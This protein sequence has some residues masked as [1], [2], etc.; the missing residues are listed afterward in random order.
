MVLHELATNAAKHGAL[1]VRDGRVSVPLAAAGL[2]GNGEPL[3]LASNGKRPVAP[4]ARDPDACGYGMEVI[5][6]LIPYEL[7][8]AVDLAFASDGLRCRLEIPAEWQGDGT[9]PPGALNG[10][11][12]P[13]HTVS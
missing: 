11:A 4:R 12:R 8:G 7:G 6:D 13:L 1:S 9:W 3:Q 2:N 10:A 5:R